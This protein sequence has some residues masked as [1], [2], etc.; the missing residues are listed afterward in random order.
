MGEEKPSPLQTVQE[1][2]NL[3]EQLRENIDYRTIRQLGWNLGWHENIYYPEILED[4][5]YDVQAINLAVKVLED[6]LAAH[7]EE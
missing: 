6:I 3:L 2:L 4:H 7:Q 5:I 1:T